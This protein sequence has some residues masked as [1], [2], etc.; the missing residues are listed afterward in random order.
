MKKYIDI[1]GVTYRQV[2]ESVHQYTDE[3]LD[4]MLDDLYKLNTSYSIKDGMA[5]IDVD[6][7]FELW[8]S[9]APGRDDFVLEVHSED[10]DANYNIFAISDDDPEELLRLA[11]KVSR[12]VKSRKNI[13][14]V[15][16]RNG[17]K[18]T[19]SENSYANRQSYMN[20][21]HKNYGI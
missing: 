14:E 8:E 6:I 2:N 15:A 19:S 21:L 12:E 7:R 3:E 5:V 11:K 20:D 17:L 4:G 9:P 18:L 1:E 16:R 13:F 10:S